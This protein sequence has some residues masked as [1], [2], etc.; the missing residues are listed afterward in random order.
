MSEL[1]CS[2][3]AKLSNPLLFVLAIGEDSISVG[4][5][6]DE[7]AWITASVFPGQRSWKFRKWRFFFM[8]NHNPTLSLI[9]SSFKG[10]AVFWTVWENHC[11]TTLNDIF[12]PVAFVLIALNSQC[13]YWKLGKQL[14]DE[15][16]HL[17][18][19]CRFMPF[20]PVLIKYL[21]NISGK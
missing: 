13:Y 17:P 21:R 9:F 20:S 16:T 3:R 12:I 19:P 18:F 14:T 5:V 1:E 15:E 8:E 7:W 10:S 4:L 11:S 6:L 2:S